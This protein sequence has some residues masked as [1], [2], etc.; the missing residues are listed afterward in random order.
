MS[1]RVER[2]ARDPVFR[3]YREAFL[4]ARAGENASTSVTYPRVV[5]Y[6][7]AGASH[8]WIWYADL[9]ERIGLFDVSFSDESGMAGG[10][11]DESHALLVGG[12]DTYA[13]AESLGAEG[14]RS[15]DGFVR[16]GGL[17][18]GSCAGAYLVLA[19][20][21]REPFAPFS[22]LG[23]SMLNVM[24]DPPPPRCLE[25]KYLAPYGDQWVFHPVYGEVLLRVEPG[26]RGLVNFEKG[27]IVSAPL[28][29]GPVMTVEGGSK[30]IAS[31]CGL[32]SRAAYPWTR[33]GA[34]RLVVGNAAVI[35]TARGNGIA[36]ASGPHL[37]HPLFPRANA[38]VAGLLLGHCARLKEQ[39]KGDTTPEG[40]AEKEAA[41]GAG[42]LKAVAV[43]E[44]KRQVSNSR[45]V[46]F[47]LERMPVT[48]KIGLK[49]WEP[50]KISMFLEVAWRRLAFLESAAGRAPLERLEGLAEGYA[51]ITDM[52]KSLKI[53]VESGED[54]QAEAFS[55]LN[56]LKELTASFLGLC[57]RLRL[58]E[59]A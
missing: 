31:Y 52:V 20:V 28:F 42:S 47:G 5:V 22:L 44:I 58:D 37:E 19:G 16:R 41:A 2:A 4:A 27:A 29:G 33:D 24:P 56:A 59:R 23:G 48:W 39:S 36:V 25:H 6:T 35:G 26:S 9:L 13:M 43:L 34:E 8:S 40:P 7:G 55:L 11:L 17:Y 21:D 57:F 46:G 38:L 30:V 3:R 15:V 1:G 51:L 53:K 14:A 12:G 50:E 45:I 54:S 18:Y 10:R 49:V 32:T